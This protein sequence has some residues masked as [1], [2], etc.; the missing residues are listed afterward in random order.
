MAKVSKN[1]I[2]VDDI[3]EYLKKNSDFSF[4]MRVLNEVSSDGFNCVHS[5]TYKDIVTEKYREFDITA[6]KDDGERYFQFAIECKNLSSDFPL[7]IHCVPRPEREARHSV[8]LFPDPPEPRLYPSF[9]PN[10]GGRGIKALDLRGSDFLY[11]SNAFVGK[12]MDQVGKDTKGDIKASDSSIFD[13]MTQ[14][15]NVCFDLVDDSFRDDSMVSVT[16]GFIPVLVVPDGTLYQIKYDNEGNV[17]ERPKT[18]N[19]ISYHIGRSGRVGYQAN[20]FWFRLSHL[21]ILT[22]SALKSFLDQICS[23]DRFIPRDRDR[24]AVEE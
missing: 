22:F 6:K 10:F 16:H 8:M 12:S 17:L 24:L 2:T 21:E 3:E 18:A 11:Q 13:K 23:G 20:W 15:I 1:P 4:E 7:V 19:Q 14:A 9:T 5:G